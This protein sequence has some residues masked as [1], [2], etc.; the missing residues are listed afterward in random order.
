MQSKLVGILYLAI[1]VLIVIL[2]Y[3]GF[4]SPTTNT[5]NS[6]DGANE[7]NVYLYYYNSE[8]DKDQSGN[9][10]CS[11]AGLEPVER[12][13]S[14]DNLIIDTVKL[15]I[16][17]EL[18]QSERAKGITTE[19]PLPGFELGD[20]KLDNGVLTLS[21]NDPQNKSVGGSCRVGI[22]W[23]QIEATVK[24]FPEVKS[25]KFMPEEIFQP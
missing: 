21:F 18:S 15:L 2:A 24:Q 1:I 8:K 4:Y 23:F 3:L 9:V 14:S 10:Q 20:L 13:I 16:K 25:V 22:L 17:G 5:N 6:D 11:R 7:K 12:A 19:Y